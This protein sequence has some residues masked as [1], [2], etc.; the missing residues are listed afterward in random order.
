MNLPIQD[1]SDSRIKETKRALLN[2]TLLEQN[3]MLTT[4]YF[5]VNEMK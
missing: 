3:I 2:S 4:F 1:E 5:A